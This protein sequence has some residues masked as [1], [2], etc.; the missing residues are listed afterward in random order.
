MRL[1]LTQSEIIFGTYR[2]P[3][4]TPMIEAPDF[5]SRLGQWAVARPQRMGKREYPRHLYY[6]RFKRHGLDC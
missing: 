1:H 6:V 4:L 3:N 2:M 5:S